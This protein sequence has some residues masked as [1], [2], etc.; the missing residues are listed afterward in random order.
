LFAAIFEKKQTAGKKAV[1]LNISNTPL[2]LFCKKKPYSLTTT[3]PQE[4]N[5]LQNNKLQNS[6]PSNLGES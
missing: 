5:N 1:L 2:T 6:L 4:T 3:H